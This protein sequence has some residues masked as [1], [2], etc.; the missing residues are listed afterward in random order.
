MDDKFTE[1]DYVSEFGQ[2]AKLPMKDIIEMVFFPVVNEACR[3]LD[4]GIAVKAAD[5]DISAVMGMGFP[6]YRFVASN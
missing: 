6:P 2:L 4:E 1:I 5:L 3:V